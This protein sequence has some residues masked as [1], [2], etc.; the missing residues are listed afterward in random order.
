VSPTAVANS[1][2]TTVAGGS[3]S[4]NIII[5][6][7]ATTSFNMTLIARGL[8]QETGA[9]TRQTVGTT[10]V[11]GNFETGNGLTG[12]IQG[13]L[14]GTLQSGSFDGTLTA[15]A[16]ACTRRY[17]G[18]I[19]ES[20]VAWI[21]AGDLQPG[22]PLAFSVQ[23]PRPR[24]PDCQYAVSLSRQAFSGNG[25]SGELRITT[26]A[27]C[28]WAAES[29]DSWLV[30]EDPSP[31][32]GSGRVAF[33]T[34]PSQEGQSR[35]G[36]LRV[37]IANQTFMISQGPQCSYAVSPQALTIPAA[38]GTSEISVTAAAGCEWTAQS[39][40]P[41]LTVSPANGNGSATVMVAAQSSGG[42]ARS[43]TLSVAGQTITVLQ[44]EGC[45]ATVTPSA[46]TVDA[47]GR[48]DTLQVNAAAG[49]TWIAEP[50]QAWISLTP[51]RGSG[52]GAVNFTVA[53]NT[54]SRRDG[55]I[56]V[57]GRTVT[58]VQASGCEYV[59]S[60]TAPPAMPQFI[61][62]V[63]V[64]VTTA[65]GCRWRAEIPPQTGWLHFE[66]TTDRAI[67][68]IG[69]TSF[70]YTADSNDTPGTDVIRNG[71]I[72]VTGDGAIRVSIVVRQL[73]DPVVN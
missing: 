42:P 47:A 20:T 32:I 40:V 49:C 19:T 22:C 38:G 2:V 16:P 27:A 8:G 51:S 65:P 66:G 3:W 28:T 41:W 31:R 30:V 17:A 4:G 23:L 50:S 37:A 48:S 6:D 29:L 54:G 13:V 62:S 46:V 36:R 58:I 61:S 5:N 45:D 11:N 26:G 39:S 21:P 59:V 10:E 7:G 70:T 52:P 15:D 71:Q 72:D 24:G 33:Q 44:G 9:R 68:R 73:G 56:T 35:E 63:L 53:R 60:P 1:N 14:Q 12:T 67:E 25:G 57:A 64:T 34:R 55:A 18:P 69:S 43:A